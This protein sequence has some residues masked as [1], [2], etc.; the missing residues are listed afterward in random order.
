MFEVLYFRFRLERSS[1]LHKDDEESTKLST[2]TVIDNHHPKST[3]EIEQKISKK[4]SVILRI[5]RSTAPSSSP[6]LTDK[7]SEEPAPSQPVNKSKSVQFSVM[8]RS[9]E[10]PD[11]YSSLPQLE[12]NT[13]AAEVTLFNS[14][15]P[16][17]FATLSRTKNRSDRSRATS[18]GKGHESSIRH[19]K[20][21][22]S[23]HPIPVPK[24]TLKSIERRESK[25]WRLRKQFEEPC[26]L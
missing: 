1:L 11:V 21:F 12:Q 8:S 10:E 7:A 5:E 4:V 9:Y 2:E 17:R 24:V 6:A 3:P 25:V 26:E 20:T 18:R 23:F 13:Q 15:M 16:A 14:D 19:S 22:S